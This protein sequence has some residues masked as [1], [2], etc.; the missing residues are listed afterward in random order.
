M[1]YFLHVCGTEFMNKDNSRR[2]EL[3]THGLLKHVPLKIVNIAGVKDKVKLQ[4]RRPATAV[5]NLSDP[6]NMPC[7]VSVIFLFAT[8]Y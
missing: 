1:V 6:W 8:T 2:N 5:T 7:K 3:I 4:F